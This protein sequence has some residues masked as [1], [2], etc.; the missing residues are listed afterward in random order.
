MRISQLNRNRDPNNK[1]ANNK[2]LWS[3]VLK[4]IRVRFGIAKPIKAIGP[5]NAVIK[6]VNNAVTKTIISLSLC[7]L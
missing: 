5:Q 6:P 4:S 7:T 2:S 1:F 3:C